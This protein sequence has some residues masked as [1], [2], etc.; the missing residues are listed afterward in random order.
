M[1]KIIALCIFIFL[2]VSCGG[3]GTNSQSQEDGVSGQRQAN[4][5]T[6]ANDKLVS[7]DYSILQGFEDSVLNTT[8]YDIDI[9]TSPDTASYQTV[10]KQSIR[11]K[12]APGIFTWW[13]GSQLHTLAKSG[14]IEDLS[15]IWDKYLI[16][17][18]V[19]PDLKEALSYEGRAYGTPYSV[20]YNVV[21]YNKKAFKAAGIT[22]EPQTFEEFLEACEKLQSTGITP[23][24]LKNDGWAGFIWFQQMLSVEDPQLYLDISDGTKKYTDL[25]VVEAVYRWKNMLDN[26]YFSKPQSLLDWRKNLAVGN[27]AMMLEPTPEITVLQRDYGL[28]SDEDFGVFVVPSATGKKGTVFFEV[29]PQVIPSASASKDDALK[30]LENWYNP[31]LQTYIYENFGHANTSSVTVS[32]AVFN[33]VLDYTADSD[34]YTLLLRYYENTPEEVR[35]VALDQFM[36]FQLGNVGVEEMLQTIQVK[37][38]EVFGM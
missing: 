2:T 16:P 11:D 21:F 10:I 31:E 24:G 34:N 26:G 20:L 30:A 3:G 12:S 14:L 25:E 33:E 36:K 4:P 29:S 13:S 23:I 6:F 28:V 5:I 37:A 8:G 32:D 7:I 27:I 19:S 38:D 17:Q 18:G 1:R 35:N 22:S 9:S 15:D